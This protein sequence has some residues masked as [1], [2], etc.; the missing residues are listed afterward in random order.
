MVP[1]PAADRIRP[2]LI[3]KICMILS[4]TVFLTK[5]S[6]SSMIIDDLHIFLEN[7]KIA[8]KYGCIHMNRLD[9]QLFILPTVVSG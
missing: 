4:K 3:K 2:F 8:L 6:N 5:W 9:V 1:D 7:H